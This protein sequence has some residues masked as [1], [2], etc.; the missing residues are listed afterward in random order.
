MY[1]IDARSPQSIVR[2]TSRLSSRTRSESIPCPA[3]DAIT[4]IGVT[5]KTSGTQISDDDGDGGRNKID[6]C[7]SKRQFVPATIPERKQVRNAITQIGVSK[8]DAGTQDDYHGYS[9][10]RSVKEVLCQIGQITAN[11]SCQTLEHYK[12]QQTLKKPTLD[13]I[14]QSGVITKNN[15]TQSESITE[16]VVKMD[17]PE[18][19]KGA[20]K[21]SVLDAICQ[22]G[23]VTQTIGTQIEIENTER[24]KKNLGVQAEIKKVWQ[25]PVKTTEAACQIGRITINASTEMSSMLISNEQMIRQD[26]K[27]SDIVCQI[28]KVQIAQSTQADLTKH[29]LRKPS[30]DVVCQVGSVM[31][32]SGIQIDE[33]HKTSMLLA[34]TQSAKTPTYTKEIQTDMGFR[35]EP[36]FVSKAVNDV[37]CQVGQVNHEVSTQSVEHVTA[38]PA[39]KDTGIDPIHVWEKKMAND[40]V[41]QTGI[42]HTS[43]ITQAELIQEQP[44]YM[45]PIET[46]D[47]PITSYKETVDAYQQAD[48]IKHMLRKPSSDVVCQ[49]GSVMES[50]GIQIDEPHKTSMLLAGTQSAKTPT[51]TKEIQTDMGFRVEPKFVSKAVNDVICQVGQVNHE[52]STQSVEHVTARPAYKDTGIDPIHVWEKKMANDVVTQTGIVHTSKITQAELIQEQ[53]VYVKPIETQDV[54]ITSYK[55]TVDAYQQADLIKHMLRKPSSDVVC[56]VGSVMESSGIQIDEPHK[57]SMLLAG[58]QSAKT[59]TYTKEIQTDMGFR[60][61]PKFVSKAVNDVICQVGQVNHEVSTQSVEHVTARPAYKDTGIDPIHVWEKK[62]ANDVVTQTG[63]VHTSKITQ[64]ELIQEQ[65]VYVKPIETQDVPITSYK[66]TVD[67]YQ[68]ADLI[69]HML[70]KPS[71]DVVCQVGSVMESSGIQIDEPHKTSMLLAGTQSAKTPTYTKE[72]QTDMGFRVEP[73]FVSKAVNDVICQVG[74]VNHEVSTQSVEHVTA[75][76][77][78]KDTGIDPIHVWEKKMANDVVTQTG[79]VHTSKITQAELIQEQ[80]VYVKPIETQDVPITSYKETVDAYQQADL[81]KHMLRKPSSDVVCQVGSVMESSGIQIDEPHK[82][83]MLLAGTQSAKTPTYTKEIQTDMGFR[84]EPKFVSKAVNDVI[85]QVGQVNHEVS[86]QSVEHVTARPAYKDTGIDPIHVWEKKMANDVVTQTGIVHTSK[87]TQA[88]LIQEQPVYVKPI[89]TQDVPITSYK[90]T[91]DAYQQ[92]DLIKHM[93]RKPSSDVVCQV[94]SVMESSG[95]QIDE[96]HKTSMLLAGT[97]SAKTPTYTKEIQTDM[98]FRVEPKFVSKAVN[99]VICQVGQVNHEVS[100]QSE[101]PSIIS[102][103]VDPRPEGAVRHLGSYQ[104]PP[105]TDCQS[106]QVQADIKQAFKH[107]NMQT[108]EITRENLISTNLVR[109][110]QKE[111]FEVTTQFGILTKDKDVETFVKCSSKETQTIESSPEA[112]V[113]MRSQQTFTRIRSKNYDVQTQSGT[114]NISQAFQ[115]LLDYKP[116]TDKRSTGMQHEMEFRVVQTTQHEP[117]TQET[118]TQTERATLKDEQSFTSF[119]LKT[120]DV[121][122]QF[123]SMLKSQAAQTPGEHRPVVEMK[124]MITQHEKRPEPIVHKKLQAMVQPTTINTETQTMEERPPPV[125][126]PPKLFDVQTQSGSVTIDSETQTPQERRPVIEMKELLTQHEKRPEPIVHKKLQ[127][128]VQP[129]TINTET[130]T[131]EERPPP[132]ILPP[133]LFDVQTQSGSVTIDSETQ[134]PQ[135]RRPVIEMKELLTQHEKRPEPIVHKKLQAMVQPTT[136]NTETQTMEERPPPVILPPKLFDV[137]TQSGSVTKDSETQTPQEH[138][139]VIEMKE[140]LT[141]HEKRPEPIVH[142]KLQAMVQ[143]TTI[144]TETQTMEERPPPV[145]LPPKLFDVQTQSGSVTIDSETQTPLERRPVVATKD[146]SVHQE[147]KPVQSIP[148]KLQATVVPPLENIATQTDL[149]AQPVVMPMVKTTHHEPQTQETPTQTERAT[150]KDEQSFTSFKLKTYD[151]QTQFG[152]MLKSQAAQTPGEHRLVVEMKD[153]ITQH[154]KRPEPIVHKKLQA[155]V[156]PTTINTETQTMEERPPPV[157]LP[158]KLFDVQTQSGS[159]T[160]DSETQTPQERRPVI[161]MKELLTQHEKRPEPIVHKKLQAMVQPTTINTETQTMEE[162]PPPVILPPKLF[163][164]QTQ[165]GSVTKDS[166][167]QTPQEHRPVIEMKELLT[168][169]EKRPEPIVHKKLQAMVQPTTINTETQTMEERPPP[170]IL[171]PKLFDVQTQSGSVTIDSETQTPLER[172]PVVAT[173][174]ATVH[175]ETK[176]VQSIP[177]KLQATVVPPL[178][179]IATQTDLLAQPVVMSM[180]K[181]THHEPQTQETPTQTERV[182]LKDEQSF[183]SF[184][185]KTYDVQTQFGSM[186]KSQAAQTPGE[187]RP[188]VEMKDMITQHE[189]RPE[190]IVHKKLQAMVQPTTIN[191]ETQTMEERPPPVILPPKLFDVQTQSGSVTIDSETQTPQ[192]RRPVIEMKELLT[193]HEKR[194][195]PIVHKKLQAMV[196]PTTINTETQTMEERPP[197]VILPPKLFDVQTQSGSVTI[198]SETQTPHEQKIIPDIKHVSVFHESHHVQTVNKKLQAVVYHPSDDVC[199]QTEEVSVQPVKPVAQVFSRAPQVAHKQTQAEWLKVNI[200]TFDIQAQSGMV[201]KTQSTQTI[202]EEQPVFHTADVSVIHSEKSPSLVGKK[203]QA[204]MRQSVDNTSTQTDPMTQVPTVLPKTTFDVV[205]QSGTIHCAQSVQTIPEERPV[206]HTADVSVIHSE[207]SPSLVGK[208]VQATMRQSVDNTSTQTDPMTQVPTVLPKTTFDVVTQSGTIHCAQS[209]QTIPEERPVFHTAD[210]SVIHSEKS[211]S[212]VGKKVQATMRQSVDNTSTQTD[213]MTQVPTVLPKTTFDVV[214]QSGTIHCAQSVQTIPEERPVYHTV[215]VGVDHTG[216]LQPVLYENVQ[217]TMRQSVDNTSTQTDPMTQVPTVLPKT[218][219]DVVTQSGTIHCAQSV[220]TIPEERPVFHTADVSV[221]HSEKSPSLVGKKVQ[222]TMRQSVDNTS[223]QT[224]PMTQV[225]TVLPKTTFDV[226]T[227]SG[228]IHCAQSVQTI[229][230]ERPVYHT[231]GVGVDHTGKLQP[232]LYENVQATMRQSVDNTSTQTDPMTQ[233]PT[234]LPK[235]T[236]DVVTQSGTIH[237]AQSVQTIPEERPV[238]HTADVSVIHSEKSPS[239]VG[240]KVQATMRQSVDN[241]STQTDPMTQVPTVLPKTTFDVVTQ[242]GTLSLTVGCQAVLISE[243]FL[244]KDVAVD[245]VRS[246]NSCFSKAVQASIQVESKNVEIQCLIKDKRVINIRNAEAQFDVLCRQEETQTFSLPLTT[247]K[248]GSVQHAPTT[249]QIINKKLQVTISQSVREE[250]A[251]TYESIPVVTVHTMQRIHHSVQTHEISSQTDSLEFFDRQSYAQIKSQT[252]DVEIQSGIICKSQ[253]SQTKLEHKTFGMTKE[254]STQYEAVQRTMIN[255][256]IQADAQHPVSNTYVQTDESQLINIRQKHQTNVQTQSGIIQKEQGAQTLEEVHTTMNKT[257]VSVTHELKNRQINK[258]LQAKIM[259]QMKDVVIQTE[260]VGTSAH[261]TPTKSTFDVQTQSG[262]LTIDSETQTPHEQKIIPDIKHVSVFH[263]SHHVQT[264][265]KKL[266]AVVYHPSDDVCLQT[267][268]VSVQPVKPVAQVFSRAPQVAHKQTQAEWLKVNIK[269]FDIQAQSGMVVKTQ[270]TQTILEEQPVFHTADVSVIHSEKS[271]SLVNKKLQVNMR[272]SVDNTSTQTDPMTQVPTVLP[273]TTFDVVT[274]SGTIHCAQ[275]VQTIPEERPVFHTAD[276]SVIHSEKSPSLVGKK[277]QATMRQSVDNTSTQTDPMTQVPTVLPK[278]TFDVVT[279][280]GT[281]HCAQSVQTIPEE[282]PVFHTA[283]VSVIHSEKSPSLVGKKVQATMR[284]SV[285]NTSTQTD[286]M[287]QVPTV[288]PK[289]TFDVVTQSG[290]IHCAQSVQ[291]IPEERPVYHTVGVGVDHTG[292]LQPVLYENVQATMR[293]SVDN[294]STQT[295]PMTQVP[296]VLSKTTFDVVTQSGTIHCAQSV[297]T[298]PEERPVFHTADV[299]VIHSEKSPSLVGKKVQATMRQSVDNTSTQTD[300]MTQVP[301]VLPKTTFDVV[302][303]SGTIHCAQSVQTIPEERPVYHTVGVGVDH[304]GKLQPVLYENVQATMRQSVDNTSTQTDPMTQVPTVLPKT[305]FDVV[306]QSGTIHCA[307]SVQTIPEERPVFHTADVSV[308]HSEKS[309]SLVGKKVQATMRQSV[310]NT[311]TQTDPMT[312]V[313]TVLPKTTFDVVTQSGTIHCAQSV[314][315]IPEER[316]VF[317]TADVSVIH[318]EKSPSLVGKKVQATMRQSVDNTSTQTDPMTQVPTV[319][320]KTTFDVVTQS[321]TI[322]CAQSVQTI[323]EERPVFHTADVSVIHSEKSPSL[324]GKKVQATMRQSVD[325]TS[326]Q[327]DPMTQVPTVLPKTTFDVVTQSGTI[328]CA[329]SVQTISEERPRFDNVDVSVDHFETVPIVRSTI[330]STMHTLPNTSQ[331]TQTTPTKLAD[332]FCQATLSS[333]TYD[334]QIQSGVMHSIDGTQTVDL[335]SPIEMKEM[336]VTHEKE[337]TVLKGKK[338]QV[339]CDSTDL[340]VQTDQITPIVRSTISSTMHTLPNTSQSTQTTPTKLADTFCQATLSSTTY[341]VQIQSGVMH[342]IDGTQ[343]VDLRSPIEMKE[344]SVTHEKE[345]TVLKGKKLQVRCDSTDLGVQTDQI[346]PIVRSTISSTMHT[347]PN[348]SQSTQTTPTKLADTFCQATLSSTTYDVQIQSGVM[349]SIDGTQTVDLRSPIEMKEMSVTHEKER[350]VLKGKKLQVRCDSTD[351]GVQTDQITPIVRSTISST[352]HTLPNTS[353]STQTTPTKLADTFCQATLSSTTYDVQIQS[354]VMHSID[355]TQTV[356]LRSPIEMKEMSVTHEKERTVLKGKKLQVHCDST[357]LGVQTDHTMSTVHLDSKLTQTALVRYTDVSCQYTELT[358]PSL[359]SHAVTSRV[360]SIQTD[361]PFSTNVRVDQRNKKFQVN[362]IS[363]SSPKTLI[364]VASIG[365]QTSDYRYQDISIEQVDKTIVSSV[366]AHVV[367]DSASNVTNTSQAIPKI[368]IDQECQVKITPQQYQKKLQYGSSFSTLKNTS[369]QTIQDSCLYDYHKTSSSSSIG[370][371]A[372]NIRPVVTVD[373]GTQETRPSETSPS[374]LQVKNKKLQVYPS[375]LGEQVEEEFTH[376]QDTISKGMSTSLTEITQ[377][378]ECL[379]KNIECFKCI[380]RGYDKKTIDKDMQSEEKSIRTK[381]T[382]SSTVKSNYFTRILQ[383]ETIPDKPKA[384][385]TSDVLKLYRES[386]YRARGESK[387]IQTDTFLLGSIQLPE[388]REVDSIGKISKKTTIVQLEKLTTDKCVDTMPFEK[389]LIE[390]QISYHDTQMSERRNIKLLK[391]PPWSEAQVSNVLQDIQYE[392]RHPQIIDSSGSYSPQQ[393]SVAVSARPTT[394]MLAHTEST[395]RNGNGKAKTPYQYLKPDVVSWGVQFAPV[396]LTGV[397]Q[398]TESSKH[399]LTIDSPVNIGVQTDAI[400]D[401]YYIKRV[402]TT[403]ARKGLSSY[404]RRGPVAKRIVEHTDLLTSSLPSNLDE[405]FDEETTIA[406]RTTKVTTMQKRGDRRV[407]HEELLT[408]DY[409]ERGSSLDSH[410]AHERFLR[411]THPQDI[412]LHGMHEHETGIY[413]DAEI[414]LQNLLKVWGE[415]YLLSRLRTIGRYSGLSVSLDRSIHTAE[416]SRLVE[417]KTQFTST[418]NL[419]SQIRN[420]ENMGTQTSD[421]LLTTRPPHKNKR[422]QRGRSF[423]SGGTNQPPPTRSGSVVSPLSPTTEE[424]TSHH[425][426][427]GITSMQTRTSHPFN[428]ATTTFTETTQEQ[429]T[430]SIEHT[431]QTYICPTCGSQASIPVT[432]HSQIQ[433]QTLPITQ[434][435]DAQSQTRFVGQMTADNNCTYLPTYLSDEEVIRINQS[436]KIEDREFSVVTWHPAEIRD[437]ERRRDSDTSN[438]I[439][440]EVWVDSPGKLLELKITGVIVPGT[441][442]IVSASE[443]FYRGLLRV[444][445]WDYEK[446]GPRQSSVDSTVSIPL[447]DAVISKAV[448]LASD[449]ISTEAQPS[450]DAKIVWRTP[451]IQRSRYLVHSIRPDAGQNKHNPINLDV[452]SAIRAG[453]IDKETGRML[454]THSVYESP[455]STDSPIS[456][457]GDSSSDQ[458]ERLS[459]REAILRGFL[460]A[461]L[462]EPESSYI[463]KQSLPFIVPSTSYSHSPTDVDI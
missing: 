374:P 282:R 10:K 91:V 277:V 113:K 18:S 403:I 273:K 156:Q 36:K 41:T 12:L 344:M 418:G 316:P 193:Q 330:S 410:V 416:K 313:P 127:A 55:E 443:A 82:T 287:T 85:C 241:T 408:E 352:M 392:I 190:P 148:K 69:K 30:S 351:L 265:N 442:K 404:C 24:N 296:T 254:T 205:T 112:E 11:A 268:E 340:G 364:N 1:P 425:R 446:L 214:T 204:T 14:V 429:S 385:D 421:I 452:A 342:S 433:P 185:L 161:E 431:V 264:V 3:L 171:P 438:Q 188:V 305:T 355:G 362:L 388:S 396:T 233:V 186:L 100:T 256:D 224:D 178:E 361:V 28:G 40:V 290:T 211:P 131:M 284:Q 96:P 52:V 402:V 84:V 373:T 20:R 269:T 436:Q 79:I 180:V 146:A 142:K 110:K 302:T 97:Q 157:I 337:R 75:R 6:L 455:F 145:I 125:I 328:H 182:T 19:Q 118:P 56:Q 119:K 317:H 280:S 394:H 405:E 253:G 366:D 368:K 101:I 338:L 111:T 130:Q 87:I 389:G 454:F 86:T 5:T 453:L 167:T 72:I 136:I 420:L 331:S 250:A 427:H 173:K 286:P 46:Q 439:R 51:Y 459:V 140:L 221:I 365:T 260:V 177:K 329:Q 202:L 274:Q 81:I 219:F 181:T 196:Q 343:T 325:N 151:V 384:S 237:C 310:D 397:T 299:S 164:V 409:R 123:G 59:P 109:A 159:V 460:V 336:S 281:I 45:K 64:A 108:E 379:L 120:Y 417:A 21:Y 450:L 395:S 63:I 248:E 128:M 95:I 105:N 66:E 37:I 76:P 227:Q 154:E 166:E 16:T 163:D 341:D 400:E 271:P 206:F 315:T 4:Q 266:Q 247:T 61:E 358:K 132:V 43:K 152:S 147:T 369:S 62:M 375:K 301:T 447:A 139:P 228:T 314:Q 169:H 7:V 212:L 83:S 34:G 323:P 234:V 363:P 423:I 461:E 283:D 381:Q 412:D 415:Q 387:N 437:T 308:I 419:V 276:V 367:H 175:Q 413:T 246:V 54:P 172:R 80:P 38:R 104:V 245:Y 401:D 441:S 445:Y 353:Q 346:T 39:Y 103:G 359:T 285:D 291:T 255:I 349:H 31:E 8:V 162:R 292:K 29:M 129:T 210:V 350:T 371:Q 229:P 242:S 74:Q 406:P 378:D 44:V 160:I 303:Q 407:V 347:L 50:S 270:S 320:P 90:E 377:T 32:S 275:S 462:I 70:R 102:V 311:S 240:K 259:S 383:M 225:P 297:Q 339:R 216:K 158:P 257:D 217:A 174:D 332:T 27:K 456:K 232:V 197:P 356:D 319:L 324:V 449:R 176:P 434:L 220:Q 414:C 170:V 191:T 335:R 153:M 333:T 208:K 77:A 135:E 26:M 222:A 116:T 322:H 348:T 13:A 295:D 306:T 68:Q 183:T 278:T 298:I 49:V 272:Q 168:Q 122:T 321:G 424:L 428:L 309:P 215:G 53:P 65:P 382:A 107:I 141:Q 155:M 457:K 231:V 411:E 261:P 267:E 184:K 334:V 144:N 99:D 150:L 430:F 94:G 300:P 106:R 391:E 78:Y 448:R 386:G 440:D 279:Q 198:D 121:Q 187:H 294:T 133:K 60:V 194:P 380:S 376:P 199:L 134:T 58:T 47:V 165:S 243:D 149:L 249:T 312:Q 200:K 463:T 33:P 71:S 354:G 289:T 327:T 117:Q 458:T 92:A 435:K 326:T 2:E 422:I 252:N 370:V 230:E 192:E 398:T 114:I 203:V 98:G 126:L 213:P 9:P 444:V 451:E 360:V 223:T 115:T 293:Q 137:Q 226:V 239:L 235:T 143:P 218:T 22:I 263:E 288:L 399:K 189:K 138:R 15:S 236:F 124:D 238:F 25:H 307:Q 201:V 48:L 73:K 93:L 432:V 42:V 89:E 195:E 88:E 258:K 23:Q 179:N 57:T 426:Q 244:M 393:N 207:K 304:T 17:V 67:A 318:S 372:S 390:S 35:V 345:R 209:V 262:S 251:Q 357:D